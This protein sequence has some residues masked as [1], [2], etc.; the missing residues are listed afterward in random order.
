MTDSESCLTLDSDLKLKLETLLAAYTLDVLQV[1]DGSA[2][3]GSYWGEPEAGVVGTSLYVRADTPLHSALHEAAH[4]ICASPERRQG[5]HCDAGS[6]DLEESAVCYL[7]I[8]LA[9]AIPDVGRE[10]LMRDMDRWGYSFRLG[11][12]RRW[13]NEDAEDARAW[14][15]HHQLLDAAG[16]L[17]RQ[18]RILPD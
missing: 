5:L 16:E 2:I 14:L 4:I 8:E 6:D 13:Y 7:Q 9:A 10:R 12:T 1:A 18:L 11:S 17:G 15:L 3:P